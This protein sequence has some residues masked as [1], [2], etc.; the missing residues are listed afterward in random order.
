MGL[1]VLYWT[2]FDSKVEML[3]HINQFESTY[4]YIGHEIQFLTGHVNNAL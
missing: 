3:Q 1:I 2:V 4:N